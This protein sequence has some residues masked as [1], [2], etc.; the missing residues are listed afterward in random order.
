[1]G[2]TLRRLF[3]NPYIPYEEIRDTRTIGKD[4]KRRGATLEQ[5]APPTCS[6]PLHKDGTREPDQQEQ[7]ARELAQQEWA[8]KEQSAKRTLQVVDSAA[9]VLRLT[10]V[11]LG[12][13]VFLLLIKILC[14]EGSGVRGIGQGITDCLKEPTGDS[15]SNLKATMFPSSASSQSYQL[16][17]KITDPSDPNPFS[18]VYEKT[19][20]LLVS[21]PGALLLALLFLL[22][23]YYSLSY[24]QKFLL[25]I[26]RAM[27]VS[28]FH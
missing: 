1:M 2:N 8:T 19:F 26:I 17:F 12:V 3:N 21:H 13:L 7:V 11:L 4:R 23:I 15:C 9:T 25:A 6:T 24:F 20:P 16:T 28:H 22:A 10:I 5:N 27:N 14:F 18:S